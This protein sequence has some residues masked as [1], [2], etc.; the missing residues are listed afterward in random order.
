ML[1]VKSWIELSLNS[2]RGPEEPPR[3]DVLD[4]AARIPAIKALAGRAATTAAAAA[5]SEGGRYTSALWLAPNSKTK[6]RVN[7]TRHPTPG[8]IGLTKYA[9][10]DSV[11]LKMPK[12]FWTDSRRRLIAKAAINLFQALVIALFI[13]EAFMKAPIGW[14]AAFI[15]AMAASL[16]VAVVVCPTKDTEGD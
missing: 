3:G 8:Q 9:C 5:A 10:C 13:S 4:L 11:K 12:I 1:A 15:L 2:H 6:A 16:I 14:K 7:A